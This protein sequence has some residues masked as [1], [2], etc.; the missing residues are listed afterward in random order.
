[1][2]VV[3]AMILA[4]GEGKRMKSKHPKVSHR[5]CGKPMVQYV[6]DAVESAGVKK[7]VVVV[8]H[9]AEEVKSCV[10]SSVVFALQEQQL[11]TGHAVMCGADC[12]PAGGETLVLAGDTPLITSETL[13]SLLSFHR[14]HGYGGTILTADFDEPTGYG[15]IIRT[16]GGDVERIVEQRDATED[17]AKVREIN[18]GIYCFDTSAL[19]GALKE[20]KNTNAQGEYYLTDAIEV[21]RRKSIAVGAYKISDPVEI[22]GINSRRHLADVSAI[23]R[24]RILNRLMEDGVTVIDSASTYIDDGVRIGMDTIVYPG[25]ILEGS[26]EIGEDC[27]IGPNS[28]IVDSVVHDGTEVNNSVVLSSEVKSGAHVGP[29]AYI[30]P[31]SVIGEKVKIGDFVEV[32]KSVIGNRTK[33]SHLTYIGDSEVGENVNFGC[34]TVTVNYDGKKKNRTIIGDNAFIGCNTNL[35]APVKV[36]SN[37]Y[38][39]AGSTITDEVPEGSLAIARARQVNKE[40]WIEKKG[41]QRK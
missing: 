15:R 34:G 11:G 17:K 27:T 4:A 3:S 28:R 35:V 7:V 30:R 22:M 39:A 41:M 36:D 31:E 9:G 38:I 2:D 12:L 6:I 20:I 23:M 24:I 29:F 32:K 26:T 16:A 8:G 21:L 14:A 25:T 33:V 10:R 1:M 13:A 18:S 19:I 40:G 5:I 37:T